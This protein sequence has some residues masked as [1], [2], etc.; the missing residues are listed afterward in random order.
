MRQTFDVER[1]NTLAEQFHRLHHTGNTLVLPNAWDCASAKI[2]EQAGFKAIATTSSGISWSCGYKDGEHIP[3]ELMADVVE[4][5]AAAVNVPVTADI[6]AGYYSDDFDRLSKFIATI[7]DAGAVGINLEDS[8]SHA[9]GALHDIQQQ[10]NEIKLV[11]EIAKQKGVNLFVNARTD[12]M[13][14]ATGDTQ[15]KINTCIER[16]K[17]FEEAGAD[18]IF[19]P[20]VNEME[21]VI[22]LKEAIGL[23][24]NILMAETLDISKLK[25]LGVNRI[26]VGGK[27][28]L[29]TMNLL[30]KIAGELTHGNDWPSLLVKDPS[31]RQMNEWFK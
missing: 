29:A 11:K 7:I 2:F 14:K 5:I 25:T 8:S 24:L 17:A 9:G 20:F 3:P 16:A 26:S 18:G 27:P 13:A 30:T 21:T 12:A 10:M 4:R 1:Q 23:P 31:Y 28:M 15:A 19:I 6:E 22:R